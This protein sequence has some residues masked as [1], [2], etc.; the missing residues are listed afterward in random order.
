M[1]VRDEKAVTDFF[2]KAE[3]ALGPATVVVA[4]AGIYPNARCSTCRSMN[5]TA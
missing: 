5:G 2:A 1:D 3:R 4:N